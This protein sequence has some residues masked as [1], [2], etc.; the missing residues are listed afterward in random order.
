MTTGRAACHSHQTGPRQPRRLPRTHQ[1]TGAH[2][3]HARHRGGHRGV[4]VDRLTRPQRDAHGRTHRGHHAQAR[5]GDRAPLG[6][7]PNPLAR[8]LRGASTMLLGV[9]VRDITDPFFAG[10]IEA[11]SL[12]AN[13]R[14]YN[15][16]LGHAH[17]S[18]DEAEALWGI[19]EA[20]HC[21]A[22]LF[23]GD[24]RDRPGLI[25]ELQ[26]TSIPV[27]A[28]WH[29]SRESG[30]PTVS[31]D[32]RSGIAAVV[33]HL[34][35]LGHERIAF[36]GP[37][38]LG[39]ITE[40]EDAY[41]ASVHGHGLAH[42][43]RTTAS[44]RANDYQG[45]AEALDR[46]MDLDEPPTAIVAPTDVLAM[47]MLHAAQRRGLRVP[48]DLSVTGFDDIPVAAVAV[49]ALT[50][51]RMPTEAMMRRGRR[52]GHRPRARTVGDVHP[53]ASTGAHPCERLAPGAAARARPSRSR[54]VIVAS[55]VIGVDFGTESGRAVV[56]DTADGRELGSS[57]YP[58]R[59]RR[60][61]RDPPGARRR[62]GAGSRLGV[63]GPDGLPAH[64]PGGRPRGS[65]RRGSMPGR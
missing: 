61:R 32:N 47:G 28:L 53:R 11:A 16:V 14:G 13:R 35:G 1:A 6:Y 44:R 54:S 9:I 5:D 60:H 15:V 48:D 57:V 55:Y 42:P 50:T 4:A 2:A 23:L 12:E 27:V 8:G 65:R 18:A 63:A 30:I 7:R 37:R 52:P 64:V 34:V 41:V 24:L 46:L 21:D 62:C 36:A 51:V 56:I 3:H 49:P 22:I 17:Q 59:Q 10:A 45:G 39:D 38:R 31:V 43:G 26:N 20:R 29:G 40:R 33:D 25:E 58:Y 19:L